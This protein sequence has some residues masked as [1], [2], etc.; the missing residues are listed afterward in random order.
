MSMESPGGRARR[1][2]EARFAEFVGAS[3]E[4]V[5]TG[6]GGA[7]AGDEGVRRFKDGALIPSYIDFEQDVPQVIFLVASALNSR[8][9]V[10]LRGLSRTYKEKG[11]GAVI[12]VLTALDHERQDHRFPDEDGN[13]IPE[14]TLLKDSVEILADRSYIDGGLIVQPHSWRPVELGLRNDFPLLSI[15]AFDLLMENSGLKEI[16]NPFVMGPDKGRRDEARRLAEWLQCPV[17]SADKTRARL[18][19][20]YPTLYIDKAILDYIGRHKIML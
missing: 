3:S 8:H 13:P 11:V 10:S 9:V 5:F 6:L 17:A 18:K 4:I 2:W 15:D 12:A 16:P 7:V 19:E 20:G 1:L 14:V